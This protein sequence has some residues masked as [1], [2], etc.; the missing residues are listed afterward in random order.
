[1][2]NATLAKISDK[3]QIPRKLQAN[4]S[5]LRTARAQ[6]KTKASMFEAWIAGVFYTV[7]SGI[8]ESDKADEGT[9]ADDES[10]EADEVT[11]V[12]QAI[13]PD[14]P[15][16]QATRSPDQPEPS[17]SPLDDELDSA[18][19][20]S[21]TLEEL[22]FV[23]NASRN[24]IA[25]ETSKV[26][27]V[28]EEPSDINMG[29]STASL[30]DIAHPI[31]PLKPMQAVAIPASD[32][33]VPVSNLKYRWL[34]MTALDEWLRPLFTPIAHSALSQLRL[35]QERFASLGSSG[36]P[37]LAPEVIAEDAKALGSAG[38]LNIMVTKKEA[39]SMRY[40]AEEVPEGWKITCILVNN[41]GT[42]V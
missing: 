1:M 21:L 28:R 16:P 6:V 25:D 37:C 15:M 26:S 35:E 42:I 34:A 11:E 22:P 10:S 9:E 20:K 5:A 29:S 32:T 23:K 18:L 40:E 33:L 36:K 17:A 31:E 4:P 30:P 38:P 39:Q 27:P 7:L 14:A 19:S 2:S 13:M 3:Y 8:G 24:D 41:D 12:E